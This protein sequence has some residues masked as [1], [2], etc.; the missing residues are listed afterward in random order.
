MV[1]D[2]EGRAMIAYKAAYKK[3]E[4]GWYFAKVIDFPG[5][6]SQG[7]T[8]NRARVMLADA[9]QLMAESCILDGYPFP[10]PDPNA[11]DEGADVVEPI[12]LSIQT[13]SRVEHRV[14]GPA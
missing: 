9:L 3:I 10:R 6:I 8:L 4:D 5:A 2:R 13:G 11:Q 14:T 12:Y 1:A 7:R